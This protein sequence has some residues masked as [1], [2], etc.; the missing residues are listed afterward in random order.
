MALGR[1]ER[2]VRLWQAPGL[3]ETGDA[4]DALALAGGDARGLKQIIDEQTNADLEGII[5]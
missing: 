3:A 1:S 4:Y 5:H 2:R